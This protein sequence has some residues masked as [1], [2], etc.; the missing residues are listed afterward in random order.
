LKKDYKRRKVSR[1]P[2][3]DFSHLFRKY[4]E[5]PVILSPHPNLLPKGEGDI[6]RASEYLPFFS[7]FAISKKVTV[8]RLIPAGNQRLTIRS[9][10]FYDVTKLPMHI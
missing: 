8:Y 2:A 4:S 6:E 3:T 1:L 5:P 7:L 9:F 10:L